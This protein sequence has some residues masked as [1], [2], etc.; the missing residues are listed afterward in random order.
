MKQN[1]TKNMI[2]SHLKDTKAKIE[3]KSIHNMKLPFEG[4]FK[5]KYAGRSPERILCLYSVRLVSCLTEALKA[6]VLMFPLM[7]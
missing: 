6:S 4:P 3:Q 1:S 2:L 7:F 5:N